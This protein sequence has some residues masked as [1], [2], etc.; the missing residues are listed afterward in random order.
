MN[1]DYNGYTE[2]QLIKLCNNENKFNGFAKWK[3]GITEQYSQGKIYREYANYP[4]WRPLYIYSEHGIEFDIV[5]KHEIDN[6]AEAMFVFSDEKLINYQKECQKPVYKVM[7][8][9]VWY[10]NEHNL[11]QLPNAKGTLAF[12]AHSTPDCDAVFD[13]NEYINQLKQLPE[14]MHPICVCLFMTDVLKGLYKPFIDAGIPVYTAGNV[15]DVDFVDKYFG[16]LRN[17]KFSTSNC[18]GTYAF[19]SVEMG[20]PFSLYGQNCYYYNN[21]DPNFPKGLQTEKRPQEEYAKSLFKGINKNIT[22]KQLTF[23]LSKL[24]KNGN[25]LSREDMN[26]ILIKAYN[27]RT[28]IVDKF[29]EYIKYYKKKKKHKKRHKCIK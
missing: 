23:V 15:W 21:T 16:L 8:P 12:P 13:V 29:I 5:Y 2:E 3:Y 4:L 7:Q 9:L 19:Y 11:D 17:F 22:D 10:R 1:F 18:I 14:D 27:K 6:D 24:G 26:K 25:H 28:N 20:I